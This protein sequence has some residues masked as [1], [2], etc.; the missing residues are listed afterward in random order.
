MPAVSHLV[1]LILLPLT[2]DPLRVN[3]PHHSIT[4]QCDRGEVPRLL[5]SFRVIRANNPRIYQ[6]PKVNYLQFIY[7][8]FA[9]SQR[10]LYPQAVRYN[11][12]A[13]HGGHRAPWSR[14]KFHKT[15]T[16]IP[17]GMR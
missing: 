11:S 3:F 2:E 17:T 8:L 6:V 5:I 14:V 1:L 12:T 7:N 4:T 9:Y 15:F 16:K 13:A 10:L